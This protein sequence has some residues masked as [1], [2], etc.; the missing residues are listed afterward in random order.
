MNRCVAEG[1]A[2][3][4]I[5]HVDLDAP[6]EALAP[7]A[8][9]RAIYALFWRG[10]RPVGWRL[11]L[12]GE[13]PAPASAIPAVAAEAAGKAMALDGSDADPPAGPRPSVTVV[14]CTRDRPEDLRRCLASLLACDPAPDGIV[15]VDN[16]P[17]GRETEAVVRLAGRATYLLEPRPGLSHARNAGVRA[18]TSEIVAFTDDDVEVTPDWIAR[19]A[20][21]FAEP[22]VACVTGFVIPAALETEAACLFEFEIGG[23]GHEM[24]RRR[25]DR[26]YLR[27]GWWR[28]PEV[29]KIGA[30]ANMAIRRTAFAE[31]GLFDP[32]LGAG[33]SGC[34][35]DSELWFRLLRAG[36]ICRYDP[37]AVVYHHHRADRAA[38]DRQL[39]AY[40]RGHSVALFAE[41]AQDR[42][43]CHLIRAF[44]VMPYFHLRAAVRASLRGDRARL[45]VIAPQLRGCL[46]GP[47]SALR[48]MRRPGPPP[49][50]PEGD[51]A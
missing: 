10:G 24:A 9:E 29:W 30:G 21:P 46:E 22:D 4:G 39:R 31:V 32:R 27:R 47:F 48:W 19:L 37:A 34:S 25:F 20:A 5:R 36:R 33:A 41:F 3:C 45:A 15:V 6:L 11:L 49:L 35:E 26:S 23:F 7:G 16:A 12:A 43:I 38:L 1:L 17:R 2:P 44:A 14:V 50:T 51:A 13:L 40:S 42:R 18:A 8:S 28:S